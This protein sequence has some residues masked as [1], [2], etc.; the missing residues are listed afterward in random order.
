[1]YAAEV[2]TDHICRYS[3]QVRSRR[4]TWSITRRFSTNRCSGQS[5]S[6][7]SVSVTPDHRPAR[8]PQV[9]VQPLLSQHSDECREQ[10]ARAHGAS[11]GDDL[12]QW[13]SLNRRNGGGLTGDSG[14]IESEEDGTE[15][16]HRLVVRDKSEEL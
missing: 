4:A 7:S 8:I 3:P 15:E 9:S 13:S 12:T 16:G 2:L 10:K 11:G 5:S 14:L 1:M 6:P